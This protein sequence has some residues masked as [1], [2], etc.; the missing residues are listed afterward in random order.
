MAAPMN[1]EIESVSLFNPRPL[2]LHGYVFPFIIL[3]IS[4]LYCWFGVYGIEDYFEAGVIAVVA[5]GILQI[6]V[7]L[8]CHWSVH[9]KCALTCNRA[10]DPYQASLVKIVPTENNG[11][12]LVAE[13]HHEENEEK[14]TVDIWFNFQKT[15]YIYDAEEKKQ[16]L[17]V[18]FPV[19]H[20]ME[21]YQGWKGYKDEMEI[22][23]AVKQYGSNSVVMEIP[24]FSEL[25]KERATAP[26]FV[27]QVFC[28]G[29]WCLDE[30]WYYS[31]FTLV[32]L[33]MFEATLVKQ[34]LRNLQEIRKMG[35]K[36]YFVN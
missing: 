25:F 27:F 7:C 4:W 13:L 15:K 36:P 24:E 21:F 18:K 31:V 2:V 12:P 29:L 20:S 28:V 35:N 3:Y 8:F 1:S 22:F 17:A 10:K 32:M 5:I 14:P 34:Q 6:L 19:D 11:F 16:F 26:F 30:Y 23:K 9:I 33:V